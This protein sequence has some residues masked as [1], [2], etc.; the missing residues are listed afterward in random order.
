MKK[1]ESWKAW[2]LE[3]LLASWHPSLQAVFYEILRRC[4][5]E[6]TGDG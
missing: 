6:A 2:K 3:S 5:H 4:K 1:L